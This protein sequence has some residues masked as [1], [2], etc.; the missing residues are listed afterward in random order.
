[1]ADTGGIGKGTQRNA[2]NVQGRVGRQA[3]IVVIDDPNAG[4]R[5]DA[6][7]DLVI[8]AFEG[9]PRQS[10]PQTTFETVAGERTV[11]S[12]IFPKDDRKVISLR[13]DALDF[14]FRCNTLAQTGG[15]ALW[16]SARPY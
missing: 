11:I 7:R 9:K 12:V 13:R 15:R 10:K 3:E 16:A 8:R 14:R 5:T 2:G 6:N 4:L 1:M